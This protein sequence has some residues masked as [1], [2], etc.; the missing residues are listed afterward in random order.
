MTLFRANNS[1]RKTK[2]IQIKAP[3]QKIEDKKSIKTKEVL[4]SEYNYKLT[5]NPECKIEETLDEKHIKAV[6]SPKQQEPT[7]KEII[8]Y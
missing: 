7:I 5:E 2:H 8:Q 3:S 4:H 6:V 1:K